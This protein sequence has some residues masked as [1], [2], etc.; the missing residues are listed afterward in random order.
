MVLTIELYHH[1]RG[2]L[3]KYSPLLQACCSVFPIKFAQD[4]V[5]RAGEV[6]LVLIFDICNVYD[7]L[8]S[9]CCGRVKMVD[10][11]SKFLGNIEDWRLLVRVIWFCETAKL[12][13][14][15]LSNLQRM[16]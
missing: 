7:W 2:I 1:A 16:T 9:Q 14:F 13:K 12:S 5:D 3:N 6:S 10:M 4:L 11:A 8:Y 15:V